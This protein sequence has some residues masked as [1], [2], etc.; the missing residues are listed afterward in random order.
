VKLA[1][2]KIRRDPRTQPRNHIDHDVAHRY[3]DAMDEGDQF[4]PVTVFFDGTDYWLADGWHRLQA[5]MLLDWTEI[6]VEVREGG[7]RDAEWHSFSVN[8][9]HGYPRG[10]RDAERILHRIFRDPEWSTKGLR[11]I[12]RHT[13]IPL[14]SVHRH[15]G[16]VAASVPVEQIKP[17]VREV[18]R[19]G[20]TFPMNTENIG[21]KPAVEPVWQQTDLEDFTGPPPQKTVDFEAMAR[22]AAE[23]KPFPLDPIP[24]EHTVPATKI[25][26]L[27]RELYTE[28]NLKP[29]QV[30]HA[31]PWAVEYDMRVEA[32]AVADWLNELV[33]LLPVEELKL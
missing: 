1:I 20:S 30:L 27:L 18:T 13:S 10:P 16:K 3:R 2:E 19:G 9:T 24:P 25:R 28:L 26:F 11:E 6:E 21:A 7:L 12:S 15:H 32:H 31:L 17:A 29:A 33:E 4:P 8:A 14:T 22:R 5:A 23:G